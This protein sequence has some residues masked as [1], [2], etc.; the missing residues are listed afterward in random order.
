MLIYP[1]NHIS[2]SVFCLHFNPA[3]CSIRSFCIQIRFFIGFLWDQ[4]RTCRKDSVFC[5]SVFVLNDNF[6]FLLQNERFFV[7]DNFPRIFFRL[8]E[9]L[10]SDP[11]IPFPGLRSQ[12]IDSFHPGKRIDIFYTVISNSSIQTAKVHS[13]IR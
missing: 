11:D 13:F 9:P 10:A 1:V 5:A 3:L 8:R 12:Q 7:P 6:Q 2:I 4:F